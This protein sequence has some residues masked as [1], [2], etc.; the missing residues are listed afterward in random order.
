VT[1]E[2]FSGVLNIEREHFSSAKY[3]GADTWREHKHFSI[4][5]NEQNYYTPILDTE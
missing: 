1:Y 4:P 3:N 5:W 2:D